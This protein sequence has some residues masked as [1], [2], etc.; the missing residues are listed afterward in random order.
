MMFYMFLYVLLT[1]D[2]LKA[3][4]MLSRVFRLHGLFVASHPWEVIVGTVAVTLCL[5]SMNAF[6]TNDQIC[7]WNHQCPK[8]QEVHGST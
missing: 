6:A 7:G 1:G 2:P 5:M 3:V 4:M 8:L